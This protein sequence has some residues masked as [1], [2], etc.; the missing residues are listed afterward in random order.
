M[1]T[2][3]LLLF[4]LIAYTSCSSSKQIIVTKKPTT[5]KQ[6]APSKATTVTKKETKTET[7]VSSSKTIVTKEAITQYIAQYKQIAIDNRKKFG[8]PASIILAQGILESGAGKSDLATDAN[9]HFGI[10]CTSDWQG[11]KTYHD[12][13]AE[14]E[15]FRKY[16]KAAESFAD[17]AIF[18]SKRPRYASLFT[19]QITD[20]KNWAFGLKK[21]GYA[22]DAAY[23]EKLISYIEK[24]QLYQYDGA[25]LETTKN[26]VLGIHKD[27][28]QYYEV[29]QGDTLY[30]VAK[31]LGVSVSF[32]QEKNMLTDYNL[33]I[34]QQLQIK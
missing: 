25:A 5:T 29:Q 18:L 3:I 2:K 15:C 26:T 1:R 4:L 9:N 27:T 16:K 22:T 20:Y 7:I 31:K 32:L 19:L 12:D 10:K 17:H 6:K 14:K 13:D 11:E 28:S 24:Y 23:P 8:I 30:S 34:G 21:A 33:R